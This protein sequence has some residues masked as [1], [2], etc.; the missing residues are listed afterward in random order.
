MNG[1]ELEE[2]MSAKLNELSGLGANIVTALI[3][4]SLIVVLSYF[5]AG[6][7]F[8]YALIL[9]PLLGR[10]YIG[11]MVRRWLRKKFKELFEA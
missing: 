9:L 3:M 5:K 8:F 1:A 10:W 7:I 2:Y 11:D 4:V 6:D